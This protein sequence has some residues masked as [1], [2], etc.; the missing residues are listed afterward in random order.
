VV[1]ARAE[2]DLDRLARTESLF[3]VSNGHVGL[4]GNLD[5]GDPHVLPGATSTPVYELRPLPYAESGYGYP[6]SG[7]SV[8]NVTNGKLVRLLVE[9]EP[10]DVRYGQLKRHERCLDFRAGML[11]PAGRVGLT[12]RAGD[13]GPDPPL[14]SLTQ[15]GD[16]G[17][18]LRGGAG[19]R[20]ARV[21]LQ[22]SWS[23]T[24]SSSSCRRGTREP[25][26]R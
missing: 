2:L 19:R 24:R 10:F 11:G 3:T 22:S 6:E 9:D 13:P 17:P 12:G 15:R 8:I 16:R 1:P 21:V 18:L 4:R 14:V 7:Q 5:E 20:E 25:P 26:R 23:P